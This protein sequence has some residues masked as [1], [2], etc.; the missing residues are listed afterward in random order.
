M[1]NWQFALYILLALGFV[2]ASFL[3]DKIQKRHHKHTK[4]E[5]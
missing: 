4:E 2:A 5:D 3:V 1:E